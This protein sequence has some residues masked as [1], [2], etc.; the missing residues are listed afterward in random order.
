MEEKSATESSSSRERAASLD[1][2][3]MAL[4]ESVVA[5]V[6]RIATSSVST[7]AVAAVS[8]EADEGL[9]LVT[10]GVF[11][12]TLPFLCIDSEVLVERISE[13]IPECDPTL[14]LSIETRVSKTCV[15]P[16]VNADLCMSVGLPT[17]GIKRRRIND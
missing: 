8:V 6:S 13:F 2:I 1:T 12:R 10:P 3:S 5:P 4:N 16:V 11:E 9:R 17:R 14:C 15:A 7:C